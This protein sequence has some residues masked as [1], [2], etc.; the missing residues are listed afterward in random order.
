MSAV[1]P[2]VTKRRLSINL[3][4]GFDDCALRGD[5]S[6]KAGF[7]NNLS[8]KECRR[9][10]VQSRRQSHRSKPSGKLGSL[11]DTGCTSS[12]F[13]NLPGCT[14]SGLH[15][16][17]GYNVNTP[18]V[19]HSYDP[20]AFLPLYAIQARHTLHEL[21]YG[22]YPQEQMPPQDFQSLPRLQFL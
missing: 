19:H 10:R 22:R 21:A 15:N 12:G 5:S 3:A 13:R 18:R 1:Q 7:Q 2:A 17:T 20:L 4:R 16:L 9:R 6:C 11:R 14:P 8:V